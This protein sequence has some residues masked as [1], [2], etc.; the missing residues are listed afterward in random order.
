MTFNSQTIIPEI[1]AEF[2][3]LIEFVTNEQAL[4]ATANQI[5]QG[6]FRRLLCLGAKLLTLFFVTRSQACSRER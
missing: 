1:R 6:L 2:N 4:T 3:S 5:E